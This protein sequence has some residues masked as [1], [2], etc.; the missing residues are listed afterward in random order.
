MENIQNKVN[1]IKHHI[2]IIVDNWK[3]DKGENIC[4]MVVSA[5][6]IKRNKYILDKSISKY[7]AF[8]EDIE[9]DK[10]KQVLHNLADSL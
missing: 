10:F 9:L 4:K 5:Y 3:N 6:P 8:F 1:K 2:D 7:I